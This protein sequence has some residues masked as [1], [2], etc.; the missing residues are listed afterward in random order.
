MSKKLISI[1]IPAYNDEKTLHLIC[2]ELKNILTEKLSQYD[3]EIILINDW[4]PDDTWGTIQWLVKGDNK[5]RWIC[6][7]RNFWHQWAL[8]AGLSN[9]SWD[10][11]ISMDSDMQDPPSLIVEMIDKNENG[12]DVVYARRINRNDNFV[13]KYT[14]ILYY[15]IHSKLSDTDIPRNV[16]DFRLISKKVL[17]VFLKLPE[18]DRYI[19]W[20]FAWIWFK[21]A[22]VDFDR[23]EW[24]RWE[25]WYTWAKMIKLAM[26]WILN[27]SMSPLRIW[28]LI[29]VLMIGLSVIFFWYMLLWTMT[30]GDLYYYEL[31]KWISVM[32]FWVMWLQFIFIWILWEYIWRIYNETRQRPVYIISDNIN[33]NKENG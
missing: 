15:K 18:K 26:D 1:V 29:W 22:F 33:I 30:S 19:R 16:W 27:F 5:I 24:V 17:D 9:A 28:F 12:F 21:T 14:A 7:S 23:P 13:K 31:Y 10:I 32:W 25:S 2:D 3:Y 8:T 20:M 11:I 6:L 4:S